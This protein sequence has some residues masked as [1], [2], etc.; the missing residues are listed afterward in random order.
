MKKPKSKVQQADRWEVGVCP[1]GHTVVELHDRSGK[2]F[3]AAHG[4]DVDALVFAL[5]SGD[6][7]PCIECAV[8]MLEGLLKRIKSEFAALPSIPPQAVMAAHAH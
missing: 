3:A 8:E 6:R 4:V 5:L 1:D 7:E 2:V